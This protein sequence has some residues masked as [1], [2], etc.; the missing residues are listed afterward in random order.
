MEMKQNI[1]TQKET[2]SENKVGKVKET[3]INYYHIEIDHEKYYAYELK[4][5]KTG[6][7]ISQ[8]QID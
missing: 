4:L 6:K 7:D 5:G 3:L 1:A 2:E 8:T